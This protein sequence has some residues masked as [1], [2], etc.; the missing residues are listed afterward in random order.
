MYIAL[1]LK[2]SPLALS[3]AARCAKRKATTI[4]YKTQTHPRPAR[5]SENTSFRLWRR[6]GCTEP[7]WTSWSGWG[8]SAQE[9]RTKG[10]EETEVWREKR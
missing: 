8:R 7:I 1:Y 5:M 3:S 9:R 2:S 10:A 4:M 6:F